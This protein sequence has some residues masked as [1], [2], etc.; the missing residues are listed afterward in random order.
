MKGTAMTHSTNSSRKASSAYKPLLISLRL[1]PRI[2]NPAQDVPTIRKRPYACH[3]A[4]KWGKPHK[5]M[6]NHGS[7]LHGD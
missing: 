4:L 5:S 1:H 6:G 2:P 3:N 7:T